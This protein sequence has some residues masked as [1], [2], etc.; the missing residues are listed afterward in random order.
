[1]VIYNAR[2]GVLNFHMSMA[3]TIWRRTGVGILIRNLGF[4]VIL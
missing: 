4:G 3:M 1:M 2:N